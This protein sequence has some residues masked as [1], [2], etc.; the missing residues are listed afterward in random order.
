MKNVN[1]CH[2]SSRNS[3]R[4][5]VSLSAPFQHVEAEEIVQIL[6]EYFK[7]RPFVMMLRV[8]TLSKKNPSA[9]LQVMCNVRYFN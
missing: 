7:V 8:K 4:K 6:N 5:V 9:M 2:F 1:L 3:V